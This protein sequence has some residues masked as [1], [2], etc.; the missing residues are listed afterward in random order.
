MDRVLYILQAGNA[1][2]WLTDFRAAAERASV[3]VRLLDPGAPLGPQF[4]GIKVVIDQG[5]HAT[6]EQIDAGAAADVELWQVIGT[7]LDHT[8]VDH[9]LARGIVL[10]NTPGQF[11]AVALAEHALFLI[12]ALAKRW[13][14]AE[15]NAHGGRMYA[16][17]ADELAERVLLIVGLGASGRELALRAHL[18][19]MRVRA[20]DVVA[21][22]ASVL[23]ELGIE[24]FGDLDGLDAQL[25]EADYVSLH[26]P[27][28]SSTRH[29]IDARRIA[30]MRPT[31]YLVNVARGP[32]VEEAALV[33]AVREGKLAGAGIDVLS[34]E[35]IDPDDPLLALENVLVT[36]HI[37]GV[38]RGT[39]RRRSQ[40][41]VDN[42]RRVLRGEQACYRI[43]PGA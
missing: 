19:G 25:A 41:A 32:L 24:T 5:G 8:E 38:T 21:P 39:S 4:D 2:P 11:S 33:R 12:L 22:E 37:A 18:L 42:A 14:Q 1:E 43:G 6:R 7:G 26:V 15:R 23:A 29:L 34:S 20:V 27:L 40:A 28:L 16:P 13:R 17:V 9:I 30:L 3:E 10:A 36:P 35:P 31:A